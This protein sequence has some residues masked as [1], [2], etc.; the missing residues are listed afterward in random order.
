MSME[1]KSSKRDLS[2]FILSLFGLGLSL[3]LLYHWLWAASGLQDGPSFCAIS[4][5]FNCDKTNESAYSVMLG[6]PLASWGTLFYLLTGTLAFCRLTFKTPTREDFAKILFFASVPAGLL[7]IYLF[8]VSE[9]IIE[10]ICPLCLGLYIINAA[11]LVIS[12]KEFMISSGL[13]D[14]FIRGGVLL[15]SAPIRL[16]LVKDWLF[17][18]RLLAGIAI[19]ALE[20]ALVLY[21]PRLMFALLFP[22]QAELE[23]MMAKK[24]LPEWHNVEAITVPVDSSGTPFADYSKGE[25]SAPV[26]IVEF[27][28]FECPMCRMTFPVMEEIL[29]QYPGKIY[30]TFKHYPL[31]NACNPTITRKFHDNSCYAAKFVRCAGEQGKYWE[32]TAFVFTL[33]ALDRHGQDP[34]LAREAIASG[35]RDLEIDPAGMAECMSS[36]RQDDAILRDISDAARV[37]LEGT[38]TVFV[39][40]KKLPNASKT[41]IILAIEEALAGPR[42]E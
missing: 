30:F 19:F 39:N 23:K 4:K 35:A 18:K 33:P 32:A 34:A 1:K 12:A 28:D 41:F 13:V 9:F 10:A 20:C 42:A 25:P 24:A 31:D 6:L 3:I 17:R 15:V 22:S 26:H 40:G 36:R 14:G 37:N 7:S 8:L 11:L 27:A 21:T 16:L 29:H 38:P 5:F 2:S